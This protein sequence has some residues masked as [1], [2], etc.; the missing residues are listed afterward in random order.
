M[1]TP[2]KRRLDAIEKR[3]VEQD[4]RLARTLL[5]GKVSE[6]RKQG[7]DWQ[8]RLELGRDD[9]DG[10]VLSPWVPVQPVSAGALKIKARP[11][12]GERFT[13][14]SPSGVLGTG[15]WAARAPFDDDHPAPA[16]DQDVVLERGDTRLTIENGSYELT[17]NDT[18]FKVSRTGI[19][20]AKG[21]AVVLIQQGSIELSVN[22]SGFV[23]DA[24]KLQ[25][26][27]QFVAKGGSR[28]AHYVGGLDS[29]LDAAVD[30]NDQIL[31]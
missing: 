24:A 9:D 3:L 16:G 12:V 25:M 30:G 20:A 5:H 11:T 2:L 27:T 28:P 13:L 1:S 8:V 19:Q 31:I 21:N 18:F 14:I 17:I 15:S 10:A 4:Y 22:G 7:E 26:F 6:I 23:L 29:G